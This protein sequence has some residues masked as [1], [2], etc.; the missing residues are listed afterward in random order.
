MGKNLVETLIGAVV[1]GVAVI[2][3]VF[4][5]SKGG[6]KTVEGYTLIGK[7]DRVD[8]LVEGSDVRL[9]GI[10]IG[11]ITQQALDPETYLAVLTM[12]IKP[13]IKLPRDSSAQVASDGLLG[14]KYLS[15]QAGGDDEML[16]EGGEIEHTQGSVDLLSLVGR[17]MFS[18]TGV[19]GGKG[20][21]D[22][23]KNGLQ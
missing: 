17:F 6:L 1:L 13:D 2:F 23:A 16:K 8:G 19:K 20:E 4:A 7:F 14:D 21:N 9:S 18:Q 11:T 5:Y 15:L 3:F 22:G 10:K 12:S